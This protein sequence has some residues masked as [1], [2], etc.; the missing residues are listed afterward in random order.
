[1]SDIVV[2]KDLLKTY[3]AFRALNGLS[4]TI[5]Q[6]SVFGLLG[7]NGAGKT[8]LI[9][10][11]LG[12]IKPSSGKATICGLDCVLQ[13]V[14][15]RSNVAYLPA[16]A[17]LF[18]MMRGSAVLD[19]FAAMN[20]NGNR[21]RA[22][23]VAKQLDL[24]LARR[25]AFMS[26]GMRQKLAIACVL[27][28]RAPLLILDEPTANLDPNVRMEVLSLV[29]KSQNEGATVLF[30]SHV[31]SEIEE[32]CDTA[33][34]VQRGNVVK[35]FNVSEMRATHRVHG[36]PTPAWLGWWSERQKEDSILIGD[37]NVLENN[38]TKVVIDI[39]G[40][41]QKHLEWL[42]RMPVENMRIEPVG[43]RSVYESCCVSS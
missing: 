14:Q 25:V 4:L 36:T 32:V 37:T 3:G 20:P 13:S 26:T 18:G 29:R 23:A 30:S 9:R 40:P 5:R 6:G 16:E 12:F 15:V 34:I 39:V 10:S 21:E 38:S 27:S 24:D 19:F 17:K 1:M 42:S 35:T 31:L 41:I 28:S 7:P 43:L 22:L 2:A 8:T 11:L 33:T